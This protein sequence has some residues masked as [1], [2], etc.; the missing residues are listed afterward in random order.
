LAT[1]LKAVQRDIGNQMLA[2]R[3]GSQKGAQDLLKRLAPD[4]LEAQCATKQRGVVFKVGYYKD[5]WELFRATHDELRRADD[6]YDE[7]FD[8]PYRA[9]LQ[10]AGR[11]VPERRGK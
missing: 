7:F 1:Q 5:M 4:V 2:F 9:A 10:R 3:E 11:R 8:R 6:V